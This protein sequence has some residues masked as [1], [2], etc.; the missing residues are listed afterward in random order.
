MNVLTIHYKY[1]KNLDKAF[2]WHQEA[3]ERGDN[4]AMND[5]AVC[6][7]NSEGQKRIQKK[8]YI[9]YQWCRQCNSKLISSN[10]TCLDSNNSHD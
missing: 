3:A 4:Q 2:Y 1:E 10:N 8:P 6:Y 5:L 9:N 7:K